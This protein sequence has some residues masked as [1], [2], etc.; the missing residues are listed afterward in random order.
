MA[1]GS[2][3]QLDGGT[4]A[5][6]FRADIGVALTHEYLASTEYADARRDVEPR[7][8]SA[9]DGQDLSGANPLTAGF[10]EQLRNSDTVRF[11]ASD[12]MP[13]PIGEPP[14]DEGVPL[15]FTK[16]DRPLAAH[17][18]LGRGNTSRDRR[19]QHVR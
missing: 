14:L 19:W 17:R 11:D 1:P 10:A 7:F 2:G 9:V 18:L 6:G 8:L 5:V 12:L 13:E 15:D 4:Y 3:F 16:R